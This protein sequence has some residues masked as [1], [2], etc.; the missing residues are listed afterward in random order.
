MPIA[1]RKINDEVF[2]AEDHIVRLGAEQVSFL[3]QQAANS[4]RRRA[5]ICA[6]RLDG[7]SLHEMLI[8][9]SADSYVHPHKHRGKVESFHVIE[10][11]VDV[12]VLDDTG[13]IVDA[14]ELGDVSSGKPFYYRLAD[15]L[16]HTLL[17]HSDFLVMH[18]VTN[19]PFAPGESILAPFAPSEGRRD[20]ALGYIAKLGRAVA[21]HR[22]AHPESHPI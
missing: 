12:V 19:G 10:G 5:R 9:V 20:E 22:L 21:A 4:V 8:A 3:K 14:I 15:S 11:R 17:I 1:L 2:V 18:E 13:A 7:D 16:F 6:H